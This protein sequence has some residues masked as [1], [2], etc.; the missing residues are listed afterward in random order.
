[1]DNT[2]KKKKLR[3]TVQLFCARYCSKHVYMCYLISSLQLYEIGFIRTWP[4]SIT[5]LNYFKIIILCMI[6][7]LVEKKSFIYLDRNHS[8]DIL[9]HYYPQFINKQIE[10]QIH[11]VSNVW[12]RTI[13]SEF[14]DT[15][16]YLIL[17]DSFN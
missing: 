3:F 11:F 4:F 15:K 7:Q 9:S 17:I 13:T 2:K 5:N 16:S 10:K 14:I 1:M 8:F 12:I 6:S